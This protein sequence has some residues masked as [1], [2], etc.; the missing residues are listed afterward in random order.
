MKNLIFAFIGLLAITSA[1]AQNKVVND[2]NAQVRN[3]SSFHAIKVATGIHL[4]LTQSG[5]EKVAV[6]A[7]NTEDR[8]KIKTEVVDGVL[9]IYYDNNHDWFSTDHHRNLRAYVSCKTLDALKGSSGAHVEVDGSINSGKLA[10]DFS[11]GAWFKGNVT[12]TTLT[13]DQSSGSHS[14][15]S[16]TASSIKVDASSGSHIDAAD[17]QSSECDADASSGAHIDVSVSKSLVAS[18]SSGGHISYR[19]DASVRT[20]NTSSGG[21]VSKR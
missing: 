16:G 2:P 20:I 13:V 3:V 4:Y 1:V 15:V 19:G 10:M 14:V 8:D 11:S 18:A 21:S 12:V 6:G 9:K 5:E 7:D 17:L